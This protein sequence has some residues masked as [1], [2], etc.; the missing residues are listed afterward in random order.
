MGGF[1]PFVDFIGMPVLIAANAIAPGRLREPM[2]RFL[3]WGLKTFS[4]PP[5]GTILQLDAA[6]ERGGA[7]AALRLTISHPDGYWLTAA[8][9]VA[10]LLQVLDG[11]ARQPGLHFQAHLMEPD[12]AFADLRRMGVMVAETDGAGV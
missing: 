5:Y 6:G 4:R 1:N 9:L 12:R 10:C 2:A 3:K 11:S 7:P 8:P